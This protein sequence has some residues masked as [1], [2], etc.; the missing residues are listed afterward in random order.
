MSDSRDDRAD[1]RKSRRFQSPRCRGSMSD[2][3]AQGVDTGRRFRVSIPAMPGQHVGRPRNQGDCD[4]RERFN[5]RDAGAAC[6]TMTTE[7]IIALADRVSIPAM[8]GQH[9][10]P[11][12]RGRSSL[13]SQSVSIPAMPGQHVG[14]CFALDDMPP[15]LR[16]Q[17]PRCRGSMSDAVIGALNIL[18]GMDVSIP[19]MPG[20]HVGRGAT[21]PPPKETRQVSIP[22]MPGQHVGQNRRPQ[23]RSRP[24]KVS[25][26]A[27]PG[28]HV[29][30]CTRWSTGTRATRFNPRDAGAACR[31]PARSAAAPTKQVS[32]PAMPGQHVGRR[33][34]KRKPTRAAKFQSPRCRGSMSDHHHDKGGQGTQ[35]F[36]S[37]PAMPGQHVGPAYGWSSRTTL[38]RF[39]S[40]RRRG[41]MSD[42]RSTDRCEGTRSVSIPAM[43]GQHVGLD[44]LPG[45][46]D[47]EF[48]SIPAMPGQHVG[49][50]ES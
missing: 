37:I 43:P 41:S 39:Q 26:P 31:T 34:Q 50:D 27:M 2:G 13:A 12:S 11:I 19:A 30:H 35:G 38:R 8:P 21:Q 25:I 32:I 33:K 49:H 47:G 10:G 29:G 46:P 15:R 22:A 36:V 4:E 7:Q 44:S 20:Q 28:Q 1:R 40:P 18:V 5:P 3:G 9:V 42:P 48:V 6:R 23:P 14:R 17:S 24:R 45:Q 16:F